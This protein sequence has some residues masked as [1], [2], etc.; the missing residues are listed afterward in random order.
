MS[1][2]T[3]ARD[4]KVGEVWIADVTGRAPGAESVMCGARV[5]G[6]IRLT[7]VSDEVVEGYAD[8]IKGSKA[9]G[10]QKITLPAYAMKRRA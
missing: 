2:V 3:T 8:P 1:A 6:T 10:P 4:W 5:E 9:K 7:W